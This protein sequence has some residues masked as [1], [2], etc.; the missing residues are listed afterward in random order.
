MT[1]LADAYR[2][3]PSATS[4]EVV[5]S[6][7]DPPWRKTCILHGSVPESEAQAVANALNLTQ[8]GMEWTVKT[9]P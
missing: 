3:A 4:V 2:L 8:P 7:T 9:Q 1:T 5:A 6:F